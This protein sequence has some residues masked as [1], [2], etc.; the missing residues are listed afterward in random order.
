MKDLII[1]I[2]PIIIIS[3]Q[4]S[5]NYS[6][7]GKTGSEAK[8]FHSYFEFDSVELLHTSI[9]FDS[10]KRRDEKEK[11]YNPADGFV[12]I[13]L[14]RNVPKKIKDSDLITECANREFTNGE[15]SVKHFAKLAKV[16]STEE[17]DFRLAAS[18]APIFRD[19]LLFR[20]GKELNGIAKVCLECGEAFIIKSDTSFSHYFEIASLKEIIH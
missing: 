2:L 6:N 5:N 15:I 8:L 10:M 12:D 1:S 9:S 16:F 14:Y 11:L 20:K 3:C 19:I 17:N 4:E 18:C 13:L 7:A